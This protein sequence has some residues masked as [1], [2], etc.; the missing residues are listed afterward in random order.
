MPTM[1][2][3][4]AGK[5]DPECYF[6]HEHGDPPLAIAKPQTQ[7]PL[8]AFGYASLRTGHLEAHPGFK[9]FTHLAG[10]WTGWHQPALGWVSPEQTNSFPDWDL[11][12]GVH[13]GTPSLK[14]EVNAPE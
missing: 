5:N 12:V 4:I 1:Q 7:A 8:P 14:T 9:V 11:Q 2:Q 6:A 3:I 13:Q 10:Q